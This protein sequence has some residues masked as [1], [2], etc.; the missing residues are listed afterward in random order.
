MTQIQLGAYLWNGGEIYEGST[1]VYKK[2]GYMYGP[3]YGMDQEELTLPI[4]NLD[5]FKI[6]LMLRDP[7]DVLTSY[8]LYQAYSSYENPAKQEFLMARNKEV[9]AKSIDTW[10]L[11]KAPLFKARYEDYFEKLYGKPNV[12]FLKYE[13]MIADFEPWLAQLIDFSGLN[14]SKETIE[15]IKKTANFNVDKEDRKSHK[16]QVTPGDH[17]RKLKD[18]TINLLNA[19][20]KEILVGFQ[21]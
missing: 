1:D 21:Y 7:R 12:L 8:Y 17:K 15:S 14:L 10:V 11:E 6:F 20:F 9:Q 3:F 4:S 18:E 13:D 16:R 19:E 5:D 2:S